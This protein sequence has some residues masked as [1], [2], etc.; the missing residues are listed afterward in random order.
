MK[1][2]SPPSSSCSGATPTFY[3]HDCAWILRLVSHWW[4][5]IRVWIKIMTM[6][7]NLQGL[8]VGLH[9]FKLFLF[10]L[11]LILLLITKISQTFYA[12]LGLKVLKGFVTNSNLF[13]FWL[14]ERL[15][16][17][18]NL[19]HWSINRSKV[20]WIEIN[21]HSTLSV[22]LLYK[23]HVFFQKLFI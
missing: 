14:D 20:I 22:F 23:C 15:N 18:G 1:T 21:G 7:Y 6:A 17:F 12:K 19:F 13:K 11:F 8:S 4:I 9:G 5:L 2:F 3:C 16:V 10:K